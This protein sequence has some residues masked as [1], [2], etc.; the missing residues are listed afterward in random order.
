MAQDWRIIG[1]FVDTHLLCLS[2]RIKDWKKRTGLIGKTMRLHISIKAVCFP[3][4]VLEKQW[5]WFHVLG[6]LTACQA[7]WGL[8][9]KKEPTY[10]ET[11]AV[12]FRWTQ[13]GKKKHAI[14][15]ETANMQWFCSS[16]FFWI[17]QK[18]FGKFSSNEFEC[19]TNFLCCTTTATRQMNGWVW[20]PLLGEL[21]SYQF[22]LQFLATSASQLSTITFVESITLSQIFGEL[23]P[24]VLFRL[25]GDSITIKK[26]AH[27][28]L[29]SFKA[30]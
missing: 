27:I 14:I 20:G 18:M 10:F 26:I 12:T 16:V 7:G 1:C 25:V 2:P 21:K 23:N 30:K 19:T 8:E 15:G 28:V 22:E 9:V 17:F 29:N 24:L 4:P 6:V 3:N 13:K 5:G 11:T